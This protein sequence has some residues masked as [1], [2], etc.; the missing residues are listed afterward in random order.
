MHGSGRLSHIAR[1]NRQ[2]YFRLKDSAPSG[3]WR[4]RIYID[5]T[6]LDVGACILS[7]HVDVTNECRAI[8]K[9]AGM[10]V[11]PQVILLSIAI[12]LMCTYYLYL[13]QP[14]EP[15]EWQLYHSKNK[16]RTTQRHAQADPPSKIKLFTIQPPPPLTRSTNP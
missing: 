13:E 16:Q 15:Q 2:H 11:L 6:A 5:C 9:R 3:H 1:D 7:I 10:D 4:E 14:F 12:S 8:W